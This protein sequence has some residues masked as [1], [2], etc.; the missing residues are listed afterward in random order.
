MLIG[1]V[2]ASVVAHAQVGE[3]FPLD[4]HSKATGI[5]TDIMRA[6]QFTLMPKFR[7]LKFTAQNGKPKSLV[8]VIRQDGRIYQPAGYDLPKGYQLIENGLKGRDAGI[9]LYE[10]RSEANNPIGRLIEYSK[11]PRSNRFMVISSSSHMDGLRSVTMCLGGLTNGQKAQNVACATASSAFCKSIQAELEKLRRAR[12]LPSRT[13]ITP[14]D[15]EPYW[16]RLYELG[17]SEAV[18]KDYDKWGKLVGRDQLAAREFFGVM[19]DKKFKP[20]EN[21]TRRAIAQLTG[22]QASVAFDDTVKDTTDLKRRIEKMKTKSTHAYEEEVSRFAV[23]A[24]DSYSFR[25][26]IALDAK[27]RQETGEDQGGVR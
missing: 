22:N 4:T 12:R 27:G 24:C 13:E 26:N 20:G 17:Y 10:D 16:L 1:L 6:K 18:K 14:E 9:S 19:T 21:W 25:R 5:R 11:D 7:E 15:L 23:L 8:Q 2:L 3:K